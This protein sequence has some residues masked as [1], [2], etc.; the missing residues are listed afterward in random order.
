[1]ESV[2]YEAL[3]ELYKNFADT[4]RI[5]ILS[6]LREGEMRVGD[7]ADALGM[8]QSAISHQLNLLRRSKLVKTRR[9]GQAV[10]YSLDDG[11]VHAILSCGIDH[12]R[13][14]TT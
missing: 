12:I 4:T 9:E 13:E 3:A 8:T 2:D 1:M 5:T 11:H 7:I 10:C 6:L 14:E